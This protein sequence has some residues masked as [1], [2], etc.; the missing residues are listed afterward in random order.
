MKYNFDFEFYTEDGQPV[1][2]NNASNKRNLSFKEAAIKALLYPPK[3]Y[4][5]DSVE[6]I[7]RYDIAVKLSNFGNE[8]EIDQEQRELILHAMGQVFIPVVVG[9][10]KEVLNNTAPHRFNFEVPNAEK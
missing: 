10:A 8:A 7:K 2:L 4:V 9:Q 1:V 3:D 6:K 5:C